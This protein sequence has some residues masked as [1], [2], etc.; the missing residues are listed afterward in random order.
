MGLLG[1]IYTREGIEVG[2]EPAVVLCDQ[3]GDELSASIGTYSYEIAPSALSAGA[4]RYYNVPGA[5]T[6]AAPVKIDDGAVR[7]ETLQAR[8]LPQR[9]LALRIHLSECP[10]ESRQRRVANQGINEV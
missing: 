4:T 7:S 10:I 8:R 6:N 9:S 3:F 2:G 1:S 5:K